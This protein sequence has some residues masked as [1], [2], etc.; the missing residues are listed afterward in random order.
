MVRVHP[1]VPLNSNGARGPLVAYHGAEVN[2]HFP[3]PIC[4][5][6]GSSVEAGNGM[7]HIRWQCDRQID[8]PHSDCGEPAVLACTHLI[9][10]DHT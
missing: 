7:R 2:R 9:T 8:R 4:L 3:I 5:I 1:E 10:D 6:V